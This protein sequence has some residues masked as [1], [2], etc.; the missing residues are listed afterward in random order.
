MRI[1][2]RKNWTWKTTWWGLLLGGLAVCFVTAHVAAQPEEHN[3]HGEDVHEE[4]RSVHLSAVE[5]EE[6]G[7]RLSRAEAGVIGPIIEL[8]G[9]IVAN[10]DRF[11]HVV[12]RV[13]GIV[14]RVEA[15]LG[16]HV[17][18][19]A[20]MAT[21]DSRELSDLKSAYLAAVERRELARAAFEREERLWKQ[22][23]SSERD[24]LEAKQSFAEVRIEARSAEHKLHA[25]GFSE[26]YLKTLPRQ[27]DVSFTEFEIRAPFDGVVVSKHLALGESVDEDSDV[28]SVTDLSRVWAIL[29]VYQKD[30][31]W[32]V[33]GMRVA[34]QDREGGT[35]RSEGKISYVSPVIDETT[36]KAS[37]RVVLDNQSGA[38]RPGMFV[39]GR[40]VTEG[41]SVAVAVPRTAVQ[42]LDGEDVV[43]VHDGTEFEA[44]DVQTGRAAGDLIEIVTGLEAGETIAVQGAFT[45]K[46][47][48]EK[49][50]FE[51]GHSLK[52]RRQCSEHRTVLS[53]SPGVVLSCVFES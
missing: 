7:I 38:W 34:V 23:I 35:E 3:D 37:V 51:S 15:S 24:F 52:P 41:H 12:P 6:F 33:H 19:G 44:R 22:N 16:D 50:E 20:V 2:E 53:R 21:T 26:A 30:L 13:G 42:Q 40:I 9:E 29:A 31:K 43:F 36:R 45:L 47:Q 11:A 46:T 17:K 5:I 28:F 14:R 25:L 49:G 8:A 48:I 18:A 32:V 39:R 1:S 4:E 27:P 10:P